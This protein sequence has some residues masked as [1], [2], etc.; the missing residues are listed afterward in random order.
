[1][2]IQHTILGIAILATA[3]VTAAHAQETSGTSKHAEKP[4][5]VKVGV[6]L[7]TQSS[8]IPPGLE[9]SYAPAYPTFLT[10]GLGYD[11]T[12]RITRRGST[13][14]FGIYGEALFAQSFTRQENN[15]FA[16]STLRNARATQSAYGLGVSARFMRG[17]AWEETAFRPYLNL[18]LGIYLTPTK[19]TYFS[20]DA[21]SST[22]KE[23]NAGLG[24][25]L[26]LGIESRSGVFAETQYSLMPP[27]PLTASSRS[28][29]NGFRI[30][31]GYRF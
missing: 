6:L 20:E 23:N 3:T 10:A 21:P 15:I 30:N 5:T 9:Y 24:G 11:F 8:T 4:F 19:V 16:P 1:M 28:S 25:F 14:T 26:G 31:A 17:R 2:T 27:T 13:V 22:T 12:T 18:G 7:P 29:L